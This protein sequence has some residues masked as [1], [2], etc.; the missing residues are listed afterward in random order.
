MRRN[1]VLTTLAAVSMSAMMAV[2]AAPV[3]AANETTEAVQTVG[4]QAQTDLTKATIDKTAAYGTAPVLKDA[5]GKAIPASAYTAKYTVDG[6]EVDPKAV[7]AGTTVDVQY[8]PTDNEKY[9]GSLVTDYTVVKADA[10][11]TIKQGN[12][13]A[14]Q[15]GYTPTIENASTAYEKN[16]AEKN[17][18]LTD[19]N[20]DVVDFASVNTKTLNGIVGAYTLTST[21]KDDKNYNDTTRT[22][23]FLVTGD[24]IVTEASGITAVSNP[25]YGENQ[26]PV[27]TLN[28]NE[29][30]YNRLK[31]NADVTLQKQI[32]GKWTSYNAAKLTKNADGK[33]EIARVDG[34]AIDAGSYK[35]YI[36]GDPDSD[37][38]VSGF[39]DIKYFSVAQRDLDSVKLEKSSVPYNGKVTYFT[40]GSYVN[41]E[42]AYKWDGTKKTLT[43]GDVP[44]N[45]YTVTVTKDG[46]E[47]NKNTDGTYYVSSVGTYT[48]TVTAKPNDEKK[49]GFI[50]NFKG[51][52]STT[53][54]V[55]GGRLQNVDI[56][57]ADKAYDGQPEK[58]TVLAATS[59]QKITYSFKNL[60]TGEVT[61]TAPTNAGTYEVTGTASG[62]DTYAAATSTKKF[63]IYRKDVKKSNLF[64]GTSKSYLGTVE[65]DGKVQSPVVTTVNG[66]ALVTNLNTVTVGGKEVTLLPSD[67]EVAAAGKDA[68]VVYGYVAPG[69]K[70]GNETGRL[71][72]QYTAKL[73][74]KGNYRLVDE[75]G[76]ET[77]ADVTYDISQ[78]QLKASDV[79]VKNA[80]PGKT[81]EV[82]VKAGDGS[83]IPASDYT[84]TVANNENVGTGRVT[85]AGNGKNVIG[86]V[87]VN[88][89]VVKK[90]EVA[91]TD[92]YRL[93]NKNS[94]EH[95][96]TTS[97]GEKNNLVKAGWNFEGVAMQTVKDG[98]VKVY[99]LYN[100]NN[101]GEH[102]Y[103]TSKGEA[104]SLVR[105]GWAYEGVA[106]N[107]AKKGDKDAVKI[108][109]VYNPNKVANNHHYT[110][111][112]GEKTVLVK[113]GWKD[114]G[115]AF[116]AY[117]AL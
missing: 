46:K 6:K 23:S 68:T 114:E 111:S 8:T 81:P 13:K 11:F 82:V 64:K 19:A 89:N 96:F 56:Q 52:K 75:A 73:S 66:E 107:A 79:T 59:D 42:A 48:V 28:A 32:N 20:G 2:S 74:L 65:Y 27:L 84:V 22:A 24:N 30:K 97:A 95:F 110:Q 5:N 35:A 54:T 71:A 98:G 69:T 77:T 10:T 57:A 63:T 116:Y 33:W 105:A 7:D 87:N 109:R 38:N 104:N 102:V 88:Y 18:V 86:S 67:F 3:M 103:T 106:F 80:E 61:T 4:D 83:V 115:V 91:K 16:L 39:K 113:Q 55:T 15:S 43:L 36:T 41:A 21:I 72:D 37:Y 25:T 50:N 14:G 44:T 53:F 60:A 29:T 70:T 78:Y 51:S 90:A 101:G 100:K 40:A 62:N 112:W 58:V 92:L 1:K 47:V 108:Y 76:K 12:F 117:K 85:V 49:T 26:N 31:E 93:Y 94:G 34:K 9:Q 99:R 45:L 17:L